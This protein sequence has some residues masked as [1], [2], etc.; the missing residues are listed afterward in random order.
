MRSQLTEIVRFLLV[1]AIVCSSAA[2]TEYRH[3]QRESSSIP[4]D[5]EIGDRVYVVKNDGQQHEFKVIDV[6]EDSIH[7]RDLEIS[8][9][10][11]RTLEREEIAETETAI[12]AVGTATWL[13]AMYYVLA[14][15][16]AF[17]L[18]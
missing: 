12:A 2:C 4:Y 11:V 7:G 3:L 1:L 9:E 8:W 13:V 16:A 18:F 14:G 5:V 17:A 6:T 15:V 10:Q